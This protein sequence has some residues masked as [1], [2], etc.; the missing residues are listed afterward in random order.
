MQKK[1]SIIKGNVAH[2]ASGRESHDAGKRGSGCDRCKDRPDDRDAHDRLPRA[3]RRLFGVPQHLLRVKRTAR[4]VLDDQ[5][6][7]EGFHHSTDRLRG[8]ISEALPHMSE[9]G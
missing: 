8:D 2:A 1:R 7:K 4:D 9:A 6:F 3:G 5:A